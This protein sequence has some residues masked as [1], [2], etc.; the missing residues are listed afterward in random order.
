MTQAT[1]NLADGKLGRSAAGLVYGEVFLQIDELSFPHPRWS[2]FVVV[3]LTWWC[4]TLLRLLGG[5][6]GPIEVRFMEGPYLAE[7]GPLEGSCLSLMLVEAGLRRRIC[8]QADVEIGPLI[9]SVLS[10]AD[11]TLIE[12]KNR[13]W[14][15]H[16]ED[17][18]TEA[19]NELRQKV[20]RS[21]N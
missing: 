17:E 4:R 1:I 16:D 5:E 13:N 18:L 10:A 8:R 20:S 12:C 21:L 2:D 3:V 9:E 14:W 7:L 15:A 6:R 11:R 19:R